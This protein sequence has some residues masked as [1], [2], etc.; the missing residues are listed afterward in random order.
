MECLLG[1]NWQ[2]FLLSGV[3]GNV[4]FLYK[5]PGTPAGWEAGTQYVQN[6]RKT[7][8]CLK[9]PRTALRWP[10]FPP[11]RPRLISPGALFNY[12]LLP[13]DQLQT[14][15]GDPIPSPTSCVTTGTSIFSTSWSSHQKT[16]LDNSRYFWCGQNGTRRKPWL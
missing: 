16:R 14:D 5:Q 8:R 3:H 15:F 13:S 9:E 11:Q 4:L 12:Q 1:V 2:C 10:L 7:L 6:T